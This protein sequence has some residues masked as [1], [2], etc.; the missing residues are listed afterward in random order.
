[1]S[2]IAQSVIL[3]IVLLVGYWAF[4]RIRTRRSQ[5]ESSA[6][7]MTPK[8]EL[9]EFIRTKPSRIQALHRT[10]Q[11][12]RTVSAAMLVVG[13]AFF[14][15]GGIHGDSSSSRDA[16]PLTDPGTTTALLGWVVWG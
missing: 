2:P 3:S 5:P 7:P 11:S 16:F 15:V 6:P 8:K 9:E 13:F 10:L 4:T 1:M 14:L 12:L